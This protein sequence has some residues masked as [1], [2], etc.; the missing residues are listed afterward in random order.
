M[1]RMLKQIFLTFTFT[2]KLVLGLFLISNCVGN[3]AWARSDVYLC[4][5]ANGKKEY[6]NT[7]NVKGCTKLD[8][9]SATPIAA[10]APS[11]NRKPATSTT[12]AKAVNVPSNFPKIDESAQKARDSDRKQ[13]LLDEHKSEEQKLASLIK[14]FNN[15]APERR[16]E[17]KTQERYLERVQHM[18]ADISRAEKN[19]EALKREL[20][21]IK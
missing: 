5:D 6:K 20:S 17:D 18:R 16:A 3:S 15:G 7:G 21:K 4:V 1:T 13:I 12:S 14:E 2:A 8:F 10:P 11:A 19:L 9:P